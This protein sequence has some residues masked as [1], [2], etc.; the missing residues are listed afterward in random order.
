MADASSS[1]SD[2]ALG[3]QRVL[4]VAKSFGLDNIEAFN[5]PIVMAG[6]TDTDADILLNGDRQTIVEVGGPA[7]GNLSQF[8]AK[9]AKL[10]RYAKVN[11]MDVRFYYDSGTP[12]DAI[13][14][15]I[16]WLGK[17]NV[18]PIPT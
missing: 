6:Q 12:Q 16:K 1:N 17:D 2:T 15:A 3:A 10:T 8:G 4:R 7:K 9:L 14:L 5:D 13:D 18:L 11:S